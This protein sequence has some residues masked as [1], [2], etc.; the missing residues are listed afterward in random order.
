MNTSAL[1][2]ILLGIWIFIQRNR[3]KRLERTVEEMQKNFSQNSDTPKELEEKPSIDEIFEKQYDAENNVAK[4]IKAIPLPKPKVVEEIVK[5]K[6]KEPKE[7]IEPMEVV[8]QDTI[9]KEASKIFTFITDYFTKGNILVRIGSIIL[10][11]GLAF[12]VKYAI[13][14]SIIAIEIRLW[15]V[16]FVS[17]LLIGL[18]WKLR[19]REGAYGQVLQGLGVAILYLLIYATSKFYDLLS[20][21]IAFFLMLGVV[22]LGSTLAVLEDALPLALF[23]TAG[24]FLVPLLTASGE[25]SHSILFSYYALL[26]LGIFTVAWYRSWRVLNILGFFFT[27]II[28]AS[29]GV[30]HYTPDSFASTEPFLLLYFAMYLTISI[31]FTIKQ[32]YKPKNFVDATLVFGLPIIAFPLQLKL[33]SSFEYGSAWSAIFLGLLY[34]V[35]YYS[36]KNTKRTKLLSQSFLALSLLF[37]TIAVPY[38]FHADVSA[39][40]WSL[41]SA[42]IIWL[43]LKQNKKYSRYFAQLLLIIAIFTYPISVQGWG[44]TLAEYLGYLILISAIFIS[45][46]LLDTHK[47]KLSE[48]D[49]AYSKIIL[50]MGIFL[51]FMSM[52]SQLYQFDIGNQGI[53]LW[54]LILLLPIVLLIIHY[55]KWQLLAKTLPFYFPLGALFSLPYVFGNSHPFEGLGALHLATFIFIGYGLLYF[56]HHLWKQAPKLHSL[57][58]W[59][60]LLVL[61]LELY[62]HITLFHNN[63]IIPLMEYINYLA[64]SIGL[65]TSAYF[66]HKFKHILQDSD[67]YIP[68][69]FL[70]LSLVFY[71]TTTSSQLMQIPILYDYEMLSAFVLGAWVVASISKRISWKIVDTLLQAYSPLGI[72]FFILILMNVSHPLQ[73]FGGVLFIGFMSLNYLLLYRYNKIWKNND[74]L[75]I[76]SLWFITIIGIIELFHL[77]QILFFARTTTSIMMVAIPLLLN[78]LILMPKSYIGW[79]ESHRKTY[80]LIGSAGLIVFLFVWTVSVFA[81]TPPSHQSVIPLFNLLDITQGLV[82]GSLYYWI[83]KNKSTITRERRRQLYAMLIILLTIFINVMFARGIHTF[84]DVPYTL[85]DLWHSSYF[86]TGLSILWSIIAIILMVFSKTYHHRP[87]WMGGFGLLIL[88]VIKLFFID[89][90]HSGTIERIISFMVVGT[91]LLVIGY[92]VPLPPNE[93]EE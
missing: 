78:M 14:E 57:L 43:G 92:F 13:A 10:F 31:L 34:L 90:A 47:P 62:Y 80:Q 88:I 69:I 18:G 44:V 89:L 83:I 22:I 52:P 79:I 58:L 45:S 73:G 68:T 36:L 20:L 6:V 72:F 40:L 59:F 74:F 4:A 15:F 42:G 46:Y 28:S 2:I 33:V 91:L 32:P 66:L 86:Q 7:I 93:E 55:R 12:L 54:S 30:L 84:A 27:F 81:L 56:H 77:S 71:F 61:S 9:P 39:A 1:W 87:L 41:E 49:I 75:H 24:G 29:W 19:E 82:L 85:F 51:W 23:A 67:R 63:T 17:I 3:V 35:L 38:L 53:L 70:I 25:G 64:L 21:D 26:N 60:I 48:L 50:V 16:A 37:L 5:V 11:F 65:F 76:A 8:V